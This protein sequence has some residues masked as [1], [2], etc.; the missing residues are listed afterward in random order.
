VHGAS[1]QVVLPR[2]SALSCSLVPSC[3]STF[4]ADVGHLPWIESTDVFNASVRAIADRARST[5]FL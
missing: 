1:D 5:R 3:E 4:I 2:M